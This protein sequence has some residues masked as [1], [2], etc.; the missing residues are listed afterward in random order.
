MSSFSELGDSSLINKLP[1]SLVGAVG[2]EDVGVVGKGGGDW[3]ALSLLRVCRSDADLPTGSGLIRLV[4][5]RCLSRQAP[6]SLLLLLPLSFCWSSV[7]V[8][9]ELDITGVVLGVGWALALSLL[10][11]QMRKWETQKQWEI[12]YRLPIPSVGFPSVHLRRLNWCRNCEN[13][14][15]SFNQVS[16]YSWCQTKIFN[17][18]ESSKWLL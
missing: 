3:I 4:D 9:L 12:I 14:S 2:V 7:A 11:G 17:R 16:P 10:L 5:R 8:S 6:H 15:I 13:L 18:S 1:G